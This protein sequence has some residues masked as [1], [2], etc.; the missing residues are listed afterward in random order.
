M[1]RWQRRDTI[2]GL[3]ERSRPFSMAIFFHDVNSSHLTMRMLVIL[4]YKILIYGAMRVR[5]T[6]IH[7][8]LA[9][10]PAC[11]KWATYK[12]CSWRVYDI[13]EVR[14][15]QLETIIIDNL[16]GHS[17]FI[18]QWAS[19]LHVFLGFTPHNK[20]QYLLLLSLSPYYRYVDTERVW[21]L[22]R[23]QSWYKWN[24]KQSESDFGACTFLTTM[25]FCIPI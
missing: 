6:S 25:F 24:L 8:A 23:P 4:S 1:G 22:L 3:P 15:T 11:C 17:L 7:C 16:G 18:R 14:W 21:T 10:Y 20:Q 19:I 9:V 5:S 13:T 2:L 12:P